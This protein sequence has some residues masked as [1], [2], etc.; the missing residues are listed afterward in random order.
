MPQIKQSAKRLAQSKKRAISNKL[1]T[2]NIN[3]LF[4]QFKK[5]LTTEDKGKAEELA[6]KLI[7]SMD[8]A[9]KKNIYHPN[10][11]ARKKSR[12]IKKVNALKK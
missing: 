4:R 12:M 8:K 9:G 11:A 6:K 2:D 5:A 7:K 3:Y 10:K 1:V